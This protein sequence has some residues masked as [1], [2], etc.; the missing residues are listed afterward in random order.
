[1]SFYCLVFAITEIKKEL[2][3]VFPNLDLPIIT[4]RDDFAGISVEKD[5]VDWSFMSNELKGSDLWFEIPH[6]DD[7]I[8]ASGYDLFP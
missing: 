5:I 8:G 2:H 4:T 7:T 1:M 3:R 6:F